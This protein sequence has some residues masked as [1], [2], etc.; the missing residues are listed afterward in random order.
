MPSEEYGSDS[1]SDSMEKAPD[2]EQESSRDMCDSEPGPSG[3][4]RPKMIVQNPKNS[5]EQE[6]L[7]FLYNSDY[8]ENE[9]YEP[10]TSESEPEEDDDK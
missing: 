6:M 9:D 10:D 1:T 3:I 5:T 4:K 2:E 7:Y 8:D